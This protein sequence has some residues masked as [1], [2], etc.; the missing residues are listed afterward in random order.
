MQTHLE[1]KHNA[2]ISDSNLAGD[3]T[4]VKDSDNKNSG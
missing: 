3:L 1:I 2:R 4:S